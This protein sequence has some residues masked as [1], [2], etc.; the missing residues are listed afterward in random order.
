METC[1][2]P[3]NQT[4]PVSCPF[5]LRHVNQISN[6]SHFCVYHTIRLAIDC[7]NVSLVYPKSDSISNFYIYSTFLLFIIGLIGNG[8]SMIILS[9]RTLRSLSV[10]RNL[11]LLCAFNIFYLF[12]VLIRHSNFY[13]QDL[14]EISS[15]FCRWHTFAVAFTGHL[16]SWQ[17]VSTSIQRVN[18]LLSLELPRPASWVKTT[19]SKNQKENSF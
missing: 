3:V 1:W 18:A 15:E 9:G 2:C 14:R 19:K 16:C 4:D 13:Q 10:Y 12:A 5:L 11:F 7:F 17:L 8:F 6:A